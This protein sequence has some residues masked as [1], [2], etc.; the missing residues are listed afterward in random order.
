MNEL[1]AHSPLGGSGAYRWLVCS[2]SVAMSRGWSDEESEYAAE[3][4]AAHALAEHCLRQQVEPWTMIGYEYT[5]GVFIPDNDGNNMQPGVGVKVLKEMADAVAEYIEELNV[6]H[7][8]RNQGN[9]WVERKFHCPDIHQLFYS[10]SDFVYFEDGVLHVWDYKHGAGIV[11]E[12][13]DNPQLKY[14]AAGVIEDLQIWETVDRVVVHIFQPRGWH[15]EGPHRTWELSPDDL[16]AWLWDE[17][18]P[19]MDLTMVSR[20][21]VAGDHCRFCPARFGQCPSLMEAISEYQ[22]LIMEADEKGAEALTPEQLG[23]LMELHE[24]SKIVVKAAGKTAHGM[25]T[26]GHTVPGLKLVASR[27]NREFKDGAEAA[28]IK[29]FGKKQVFTK[30]AFKSPAQIDAIPGGKDFTARWAFKP[31]GGTTVAV[32]SDPRKAAKREVKELF[33]PVKQGA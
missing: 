20:D 9:S 4:T 25:L 2:G 16:D 19:A 17:C 5:E 22:E 31:Q 24:L 33:K 29:E 8:E 21:T 28:A 14:Y 32:E 6:W 10:T 12:A 30:P 15:Y 1:P 26:S 11:V 18:V 7:P 3:G 23:R 27:T 13:E